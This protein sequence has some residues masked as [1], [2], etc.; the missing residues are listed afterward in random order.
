[1]MRGFDVVFVHLDRCRGSKELLVEEMAM[2]SPTTT[3][4]LI[5]NELIHICCIGCQN[6]NEKDN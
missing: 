1:M 4:D 5:I 3:C 2:S 6:K